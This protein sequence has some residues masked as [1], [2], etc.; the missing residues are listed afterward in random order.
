MTREKSKNKENENKA[1]AKRSKRKHYA[2]QSTNDRNGR[3]FV[4]MVLCLKTSH[5]MKG[6]TFLCV[7]WKLHLKSRMGATCRVHNVG[8]F[9][10]RRGKSLICV[11]PE[12]WK[13][14]LRPPPPHYPKWCRNLFRLWRYVAQHMY[15][16]W[17]TATLICHIRVFPPNSSS[18]NF[19]PCTHFSAC[20]NIKL[21]SALEQS[22]K[23]LQVAP[24]SPML[25]SSGAYR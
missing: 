14:L 25:L 13:R 16:F 24:C 12:K 3:K 5:L 20:S 19:R 6:D 8:K 9:G 22:A 17:N 18:L 23:V 2:K 10:M 1:Q 11:V 21:T 7:F 4:R 15:S